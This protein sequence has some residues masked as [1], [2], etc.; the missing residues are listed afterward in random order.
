[1]KDHEKV[2]HESC[3]KLILVNFSK[4]IFIFEKPF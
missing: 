3:Q 1:M 4:E 2:Y